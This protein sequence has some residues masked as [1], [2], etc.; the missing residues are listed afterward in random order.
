MSDYENVYA[1]FERHNIDVWISPD[2]RNGCNVIK[3][4]TKRHDEEI[5]IDE[6]AKLLAWLSE[7]G[8]LNRVDIDYDW[9]ENPYE[10]VNTLIAYE[11][12]EEYKE[13]VNDI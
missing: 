7:K 6:R 13:Q 2:F 11:V 10:I 12:L 8:Y 4:D 5:R 1:E 9:E 3:I